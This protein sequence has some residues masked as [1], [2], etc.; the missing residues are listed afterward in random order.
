MLTPEKEWP[1]CSLTYYKNGNKLRIIQALKDDPR[2]TFF[3]KGEPL[4][5]EN[6]N[7]YRKRRIKDRFNKSILLEYAGKAGWSLK[8]NEIWK[9]NNISYLI[10]R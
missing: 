2:W 9:P 6:L 3:V 1:V 5:L 4:E 8:N 10:K 7:Y